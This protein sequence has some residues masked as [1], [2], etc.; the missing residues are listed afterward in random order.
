MTR[1]RRLLDIYAAAAIALLFLVS[2]VN[3]VWL[4]AFAVALATSAVI[5]FPAERPR[6]IAV[7]LTGAA[8]GLVVAALVRLF[9]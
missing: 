1:E 2:T 4:V 3:A 6:I 7:T 8:T 9:A 5:L